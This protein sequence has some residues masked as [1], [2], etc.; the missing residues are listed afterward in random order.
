LL[1]LAALSA[2]SSVLPAGAAPD[3]AGRFIRGTTERRLVERTGSG[4]V[5]GLADTAWHNEAA[6]VW[7]LA[8]ADDGATLSAAEAATRLTHRARQ[9]RIGRLLF[10]HLLGWPGA[11]AGATPEG[12]LPLGTRRLRFLLERPD[13]LFPARLAAWEASLCVDSRSGRDAGCGPFRVETRLAPWREEIRNPSAA[14]GEIWSWERAEPAAAPGSAIPL[15]ELIGRRRW[16][17]VD[18]EAARL[19]FLLPPL[20]AYCRT[21]APRPRAGTGLL[22]HLALILPLELR[23]E[24]GAFAAHLAAGPLLPGG[25]RGGW[26]ATQRLLPGRPRAAGAFSAPVTRAL[27]GAPARRAAVLRY[28]PELPVLHCLA[29]RI[30]ALLWPAGWDVTPHPYEGVA[31]PDPPPEGAAIIDLRLAVTAKGPEAWDHLRLL[32]AWADPATIAAWEAA[33]RMRA[34][35]AALDLLEEEWRMAEDLEARVLAGGEVIPLLLGAVDWWFEAPSPPATLLRG[36]APLWGEPRA[37]LVVRSDGGRWSHENQ[38]R[39]DDE[40]ALHP[41]SR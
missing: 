2:A 29:E 10:R 19:S 8:L 31:E 41:E 4:W 34:P 18:A 13:P 12:I 39:E 15:L 40:H 11:E 16:P 14:P 27:E 26:L 36:I 24:A 5:A 30:R 7:T 28:S 3:L 32:L 38:E 25:E 35:E 6:T 17:D 22:A 37:P 33:A 21:E 1:G 20:P 9:S 23:A